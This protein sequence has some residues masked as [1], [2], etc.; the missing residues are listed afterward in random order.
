MRGLYGSFPT[1]GVWSQEY[2]MY[3]KVKTAQHG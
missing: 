3:F 2:R 1:Q